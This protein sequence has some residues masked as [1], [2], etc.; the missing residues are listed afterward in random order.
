MDFSL[1]REQIAIQ[2]AAAEFARGEFDPEAALE[3][4]QLREFPSEIWKKA[5]ELGFIGVHVEEEYG[6]QGFGRLEN[7]IIVEAFCRQDSGTVSY[8]HLTLPTN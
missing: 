3:H 8:T 1:D 6:G 4:D 5:C 7:A 2:Q